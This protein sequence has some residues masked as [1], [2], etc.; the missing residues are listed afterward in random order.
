MSKPIAQTEFDQIW[1]AALS[2]NEIWTW[3]GNR[4]WRNLPSKLGQGQRQITTLRD[5]FQ[6]WVDDV[7][8]DRP[9]HLDYLYQIP[10]LTLTFYLSGNFRIINPGLRH[11]EDRSEVSG[12]SCICYLPEIRSIEYYAEKQSLQRMTLSIDVEFLRAYSGW[13]QIPDRIRQL[14]DGRSVEPF[15]QTLGIQSAQ[16]QPILQ[17][18]LACPYR[19]A[20]RQLYLESK[21]LELLTLQFWRWAQ[22]EQPPAKLP[23]WKP[24]DLEKLYHAQEILRRSLDRPQVDQRPPSLLELARQVGLNDCKLK[25]G[26]RQVFGTTVFGYLRTY[27]MKQAQRLLIETD[28]SITEIAYAVGYGSLPAFSNAFYRQFGV[29]P[30]AY[31]QQ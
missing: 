21:S 16:H 26:F 11:E 4:G 22:D 9:I 20:M 10:Q 14:I 28:T 18:I 27:Q 25:Q 12:E 30:R 15:H 6:L 3:Q 2:Q 31:R 24:Q 19:G 29:S 5:G 13:Q 8:Y 1:Q 7:I 17:Q 23:Q